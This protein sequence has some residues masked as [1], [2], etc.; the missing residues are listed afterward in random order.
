[1]EEETPLPEG[2]YY[3]RE[4]ATYHEMQQRALQ[5]FRA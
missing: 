5:D 4:R 2:Y 1:M 3:P